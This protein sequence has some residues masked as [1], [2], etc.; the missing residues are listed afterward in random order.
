MVVVT[1]AMDVGWTVPQMQEAARM[2]AFVEWAKGDLTNEYAEAIRKLG[3]DFTIVAQTGVSYLPPELVGAFVAGLIE[4]G[5]TD[6]ELDRMMKVNPAKLLG[7][8]VQ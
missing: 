4:H 5:F 3:P 6:Q 8:A 2:G 7:L 1:H